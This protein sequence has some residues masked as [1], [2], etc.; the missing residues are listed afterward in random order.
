M[1]Y[2][3]FD[4]KG[5]VLGIFLTEICPLP[6]DK[7]YVLI[8]ENIAER[9]NKCLVGDVIR[10]NTAYDKDKVYDTFEDV[11]VKNEQV[12]IIVIDE[13]IDEDKLMMAEAIADLYE[14]LL[15]IQGGL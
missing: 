1:K 13:T 15:K 2:I 5:F 14:Q 10:A 12:E 9:L 4:E 6:L 7:E 11:F 3:T 8:S